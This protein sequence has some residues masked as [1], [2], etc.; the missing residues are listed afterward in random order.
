MR[1]AWLANANQYTILMNNKI[2]V[3]AAAL[4]VLCCLYFVRLS[5]AIE[6]SS[7]LTRVESPLVTP[8]ISEVSQKPTVASFDGVSLKT[9][10]TEKKIKAG[11]AVTVE[12]K[13]GTKLFF[14]AGSFVYPSGKA[15]EG[16]VRLVVEECYDVDEML[17]AKLST[18]S[19]GRRLETAG[20]IKVQAFVGSTEVN[21]R[22]DG[23]YNIYFPVEGK[24]K[25]D[26]ELFYGYRD[27]SGK[28]DWKLEET[29]EPIAETV[30]PSQPAS[31]RND[32]F[33]QISA[34]QY[35]CGTRI[36]E[37]DYFNW[38]L[39]NGQNLNQWFVSNFNPDPSMLDDFCARRMYA[40]ITF[41]IN[42]DGS[43]RDY[44]VSHTSR[45]QY[46][47]LLASTLSQMPALDMEKFMP[48]YTEDHACILSFGR[49]QES[50]A[51]EFIERFSKKYDYADPKQTMTDVATEDLNYYL[52]SSTELGWINCDRFISNDRPLVDVIVEVPSTSE[53]SVSMIFD[54]DKCILSAMKEGNTFVFHQVPSNTNVRIITLDNAG[55]APRMEVK[56]TNTS[57]KSHLVKDAKPI[58]L[59]DL[60]RALCWN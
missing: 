24:R 39:S 47:R 48:V 8:S 46:D 11:E 55:G 43:F 59:A 34:S 56:S 50:S 60:D 6:A 10:R 27:S 25:S 20:M 17:A 22:E 4:S 32:C 54:Q 52:F 41:H 53:A 5:N 36:Q 31:I 51:N 23:R 3:S 7:D 9:T 18:T 13:K 21:L 15:V 2:I 30:S 57:T 16:K 35:R 28:I 58:T 42:E 45:E 14:P 38:P 12:C 19:E 49:Q 44:Y 37:M 29:S 1:M 33:V 40:Q 26:F